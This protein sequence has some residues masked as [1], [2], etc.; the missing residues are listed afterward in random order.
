MSIP[1]PADMAANIQ[2][3]ARATIDPTAVVRQAWPMPGNSGLSFGA[4]VDIGQTVIPLVVRLAPPG[5]RKRGNTDVVRVVPLLQALAAKGVPVAA[6]RWW[7]VDAHQFGTDAVIQD[8]LDALP[9]HMSDAAIS[10]T[11]PVAE[12]LGQ[13]I[14][15][16]ARVHHTTPPPGWERPRT[17]PEE[18]A[19]WT[20]LLENANDP[21]WIRLG[22]ALRDAL[23]ADLPAYHDVGIVHG[24]FQTNNVLYDEAGRLV[25]IIDWE[26]SGIGAQLLDLAWLAI[27]TDP[28][29]WEPRFRGT[30]RVTADAAWLRERYERASGRGTDRFD[31]FRALA[32]YRFGVIT[33]FNLRLHRTGHRVDATWEDRADSIPFL[34]NRGL[35]LLSEE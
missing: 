33:A 9:L 4:D 3:F 1:T 29:C 20:P 24:D 32:C 15:A 8:R 31:W 17:L 26:L 23:L 11:V 5:V 25:A 27:F 2:A 13:A 18:I 19:F 6:I 35:R 16:L 28:E 21:A 7:M 22:H 34:F 14:G 10:A 30:M 12:A